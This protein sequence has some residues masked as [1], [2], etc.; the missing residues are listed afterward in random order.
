[1]RETIMK[2]MI[3]AFILLIAFSV[4]AAGCGKKGAST[5]G[6]GQV[7]LSLFSRMDR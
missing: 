2:K 4:F 6:D 1:M 3:S 5:D 7:T